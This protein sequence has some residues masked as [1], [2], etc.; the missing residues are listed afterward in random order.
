MLK[1]WQW[2][3]E[4][5]IVAQLQEF[6]FL[7]Q[8]QTDEE[9]LRLDNKPTRL[10]NPDQAIDHSTMQ[11]LTPQVLLV[12]PEDPAIQGIHFQLLNRQTSPKAPLPRNRS[13]FS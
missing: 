3:L 7:R 12:P 1:Q 13:S 8:H 10:P 5:T 6:T 11:V 4:P 2:M 9:V